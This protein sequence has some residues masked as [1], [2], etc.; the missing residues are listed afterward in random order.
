MLQILMCYIPFPF[1][2]AGVNWLR[3]LTGRTILPSA[4]IPTKW[5][6]E[7]QEKKDR[8]SLD[9]ASTTECST[10]IAAQT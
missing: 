2:S 6:I 3:F 4:S 9:S 8:C 1:N 5:H 7:Y 10:S